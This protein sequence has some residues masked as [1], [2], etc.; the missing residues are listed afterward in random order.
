MA[1]T[2][3][4]DRLVGEAARRQAAIN[5]DGT[6]YAAKRKMGTDHKFKLFGKEYSPQQVSAFILQK[7]KQD[8]EAYL[9][10]TVEEVVITCP[11]YFDDNQRTATKDAV[12]SRA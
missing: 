3:E 9:G 1:F 4:G 7:I 11:A 10:D 6:I 2:K 5:P 12:R 8:A